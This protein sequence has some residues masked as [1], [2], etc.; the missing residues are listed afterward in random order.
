MR[1]RCA[2][3]RRGALALTAG[4]LH[5]FFQQKDAAGGSWALGSVQCGGSGLFCGISRFLCDVLFI[6]GVRVESIFVVTAVAL[7]YFISEVGELVLLFLV[8]LL[9]RRIF[10]FFLGH[11]IGLMLARR[12]FG[13]CRLLVGALIGSLR[14]T[15]SKRA[16]RSTPE[17]KAFSRDHSGGRSVA[18]VVAVFGTEFLVR[19]LSRS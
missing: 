3:S 15:T 10:G 9:L 6:E 5:L 19:H 2:G 13:H 12:L 7:I 4:I 18:D 14:R 16:K 8:F 1:R 11:T 17:K